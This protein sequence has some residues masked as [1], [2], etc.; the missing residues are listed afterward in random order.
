MEKLFDPAEKL[1]HHAREIRV[2]GGVIAGYDQGEYGGKIS[3]ISAYGNEQILVN[4]NFKGFYVLD[5]R[6]FALSGFSNMFS[7]RGRLNEIV[8][9]EEKWQ[10]VQI[11]DFDSCP[12]SYMILD[13]TVYIATNKALLVIENCEIVNTFIMEAAWGGLFPNSMSFENAKMYIGMKNGMVSVGLEDKKIKW[14]PLA[15]K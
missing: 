14:Y 1:F 11:L 10:A 2:P 15:S 3:F 6:L 7:D 8:L 13:K 4:E 12:E 9:S 5:E